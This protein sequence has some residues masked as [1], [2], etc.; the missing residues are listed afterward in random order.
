MP[1]NILLGGAGKVNNSNTSIL[2][3]LLTHSPNC[4]ING[5]VL[6]LAIPDDVYLFTLAVLITYNYTA[7]NASRLA[8][9]MARVSS[10]LQ[11]VAA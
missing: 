5:G 6:S 2:I 10:L 7:L 9:Y 8:I 4:D 1:L 3:T 11:I